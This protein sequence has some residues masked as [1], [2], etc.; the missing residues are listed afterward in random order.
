M[1]VPEI[2]MMQ[3]L[4][5]YVGGISISCIASRITTSPQ[6]P[7]LIFP[8]GGVLGVVIYSV[9]LSCFIPLW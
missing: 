3:Q 8:F 7:I 2:W 1:K 6:V 4:A 9:I 5:F